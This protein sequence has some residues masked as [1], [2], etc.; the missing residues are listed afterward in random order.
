M[1]LH[2]PAK[3]SK[4]RKGTHSCRECKR[5]KVKCIF[6]SSSDVVCTM[7]SRRGSRCTSQWVTSDTDEISQSTTYANVTF[8]ADSASPGLAINSTQRQPGPHTGHTGTSHRALSRPKSPA[9]MLHGETEVSSYTNPYKL[10]L[11]Q[12]SRKMPALIDT[13]RQLEITHASLGLHQLHLPVRLH[14]Q[15]HRT[16]PYS[17]KNSFERSHCIQISCFF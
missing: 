9:L 11:T 14:Q 10:A 15:E 16:I 2:T 5:R 6:A 3:Q 1:E 12:G 4:V 8:V 17:P 13:M 7:C